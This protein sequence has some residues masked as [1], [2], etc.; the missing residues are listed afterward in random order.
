MR[1]TV[2]ALALAGLA[3]PALADDTGILIVDAAY[4]GTLVAQREVL[5]A[6]C[7]GGAA[8]ACFGAGLGELTGT[9]E[10]LA[11][12]MYRH[13]AV[14]PGNSAAAMIFGMDLPADAQPANP[15]PAP[16]SYDGLRAIFADTVAGLDRARARF[17][18]AGASG[19][20]VLLLDPARIRLDID[21]DGTL[22]EAETLAPLVAQF[23]ALFAEQL[24]AAPASG[25]SKSKAGA[26]AGEAAGIGFDRADAL[27][28]AGYSQVVATPLDF[29]LAHDFSGFY[30]AYLHR[31][32]PRAG[33]P[34]QDYN[35][36]GELFFDAESD[37]GL[38]D[39]IAAIHM[40]R[41]PV[42]DHARLAG[43]GDRL[44]SITDLS[45]RNWAA[46]LAETDDDREL[47]PSPDQTSLV[48]GLEVTSEIVDAWAATLDTL[49]LILDGKLLVPH[50]RFKQG[51]DIHA[52]LTEATT[53]DLVM[54]LAGQAALPFL[55]DGPIADADS[56]AAGNR[57]L[58]P[59]WPQY[60]FWFN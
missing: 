3:M 47:L 4:D 41:F 43:V 59:Q 54:L 30:D 10:A 15:D 16:L 27:W 11:Q 23:A 6:A 29:L 26:S 46:I 50:W 34:M 35:Q 9:Y 12:A 17:E 1:M 13:G 32:F 55:K 25:K 37:A 48:P 33:L 31:V 40:L 14:V 2:L 60:L 36:G 49:D 44:K 53:T 24:A 56:F 38:A 39:M 19:E 8:M 52:Y 5:G 20:D 28:L 45:R 22:G 18:T 51:F 42:T 21:G 58:G 7:D 57:V